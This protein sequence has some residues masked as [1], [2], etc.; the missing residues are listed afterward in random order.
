MRELLFFAVIL[1]SIFFVNLGFTQTPNRC[2][3]FT[4]SIT[5][6]GTAK[7]KLD[8]FL[9]VTWKYW[10]TEFP[11]WATYVGYPGQNDRW[12]DQSLAALERRKTEVRCQLKVL[13]S[14]P[15]NS[16]KAEDRVTYDLA[17]HDFEK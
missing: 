8:R 3:E 11:E 6:N 17:K 9:Q 2:A 16:L 1:T 4:Q 7:Q 13:N 10:M 12:T 15:R 5:K 14:I